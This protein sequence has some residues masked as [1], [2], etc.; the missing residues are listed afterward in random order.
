[1]SGFFHHV[2]Q[3]CVFVNKD[4]ALSVG[5]FDSFCGEI[6]Y[7]LLVHSLT[8]I[9]PISALI[10]CARS[11]TTSSIRRATRARNSSKSICR[12]ARFSPRSYS[13]ARSRAR[14]RWR[15]R[16]AM[17]HRRRDRTATDNPT[18]VSEAARWCSHVH[19]SNA[20]RKR[21]FAARGFCTSPP[22]IPPHNISHVKRRICFDADAHKQT[23]ATP[24]ARR[25]VD[26]SH[27]N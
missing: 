16:H 8:P 24:K 26:A 1:M 11:T 12:A 5:R 27:T 3:N 22:H 23:S 10:R 20:V 19:Y 18:Q 7:L 6:E 15:W 21:A 13:I 4:S 17:E 2:L 14:T 9:K 25:Y